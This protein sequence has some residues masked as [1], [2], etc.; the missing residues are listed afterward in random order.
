MFMAIPTLTFDAGAG[1]MRVS[2]R[3]AA[4][5]IF[6]AERQASINA[7]GP[8]GSITV[9]YSHGRGSASVTEAEIPVRWEEGDN[10]IAG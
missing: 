6:I 9:H 3:A 2:G 4:L 1:P 5:M 10:T 7:H 8:V